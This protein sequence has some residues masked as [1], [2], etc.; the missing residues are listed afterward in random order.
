MVNTIFLKYPSLINMIT[1]HKNVPTPT[2]VYAN[3]VKTSWKNL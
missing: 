2:A 3:V 1:L